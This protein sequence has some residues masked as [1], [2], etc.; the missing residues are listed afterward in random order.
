MIAGV[1]WERVEGFLPDQSS[2]ASQYFPEGLVFKNVSIGGVVQDYTVKKSFPAVHED[3]LWYNWAPRVS[4]TYDLT[5]DGKTVLK[6]SWGRYLDQI[7]TG[8]PP[9]P[10]GN[11]SQTY[12]W[13]D[14]GDLVFQPGNLT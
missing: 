5:G 10:N 6:A 13:V 2:P 7:N 14:N 4:A 8:T 1:R 9:N 11:I 3:P 12:N